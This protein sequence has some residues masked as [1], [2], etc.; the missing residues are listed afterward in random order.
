M[1]LVLAGAIY[2]ERIPNS[3]REAYNMPARVLNDEVSWSSEVARWSSGRPPSTSL[4]TVKA[5]YH[6]FQS[7]A[8]GC[9]ES[10]NSVALRF[11]PTDVTLSPLFPSAH[12]RPRTESMSDLRASKALTVVE[13]GPDFTF[14]SSSFKDGP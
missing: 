11:C 3:T 5:R 2:E 4:S 10:V 12:V 8:G 13:P 6:G 14:D 7:A 1:S 9:V